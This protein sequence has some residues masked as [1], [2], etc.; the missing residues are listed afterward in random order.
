MV[1]AAGRTAPVILRYREEN[2]ESIRDLVR[3]AK[4]E[5]PAAILGRATLSGHGLSL[6]PMVL[7]LI[8]EGG[9]QPHHVDVDRYQNGK[10]IS[11]KRS[12][13]VVF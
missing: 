5:R 9:L 2:G 6:R 10:K 12:R 1:D 3:L 11:P 13:G 4:L 7:F 8:K